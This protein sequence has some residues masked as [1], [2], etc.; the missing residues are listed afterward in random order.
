MT[1]EAMALEAGKRFYHG[2]RQYIYCDSLM[3]LEA[4]L[5]NLERSRVDFERKALVVGAALRQLQQD[6]AQADAPVTAQ[7]EELG[8]ELRKRRRLSGAVAP[9]A[10]QRP[11]WHV[12]IYEEKR[13][14]N[15]AAE[16]VAEK[17]QGVSQAMARVH[18]TVQQA[19]ASVDVAK[20]EAAPLLGAE[21]LS[22]AREARNGS[23]SGLL[24]MLGRSDL[25]RPNHVVVL[26]ELSVAAVW[27]L[28]GVSRAFRGWCSLALVAMPRV[29]A[30]GGMECIGD[31]VRWLGD[32]TTTVSLDL[33]TLA[34]GGASDVLPTKR[35]PCESF[36]LG[37]LPGGRL[38]VAGGLV[39]DETTA[40][41]F[42][43]ADGSGTTA[44]AFE[45][46]RGGVAWTSLPAMG[47]ARAEAAPAV[48]LYDGRLLVAGGF[49]TAGSTDLASVEVLAA[50]GS[51]WATLAPMASA[52]YGAAT[53]RLLGGEVIIAGGAI[54]MNQP[55]ASAELWEPTTNVWGPLPSM[56]QS[57]YGAA[58][59]VLPS[60]RFAVLGGA[61]P[62]RLDGCLNGYGSRDAEA[63]DPVSRAWQELPLMPHAFYKGAAV[64]V[65]GGLL[66][67]GG[68]SHAYAMLF[69]EESMRWFT[70]PREMPSSR[71]E[72]ALVHAPA[73]DF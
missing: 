64:A 52:R 55:L 39:N 2:P 13:P 70:L 10:G 56:A 12:E 69:E 54:G 58:G 46:A 19:R 1:L 26:G 16:E 63:Y 48:S 22:V 62:T 65:A 53:G 28:M 3:A 31:G 37:Q 50:D 68:S 61:K 43:W 33:A 20:A 47:I 73:R 41:A 67:V 57:R 71:I 40:A 23:C 14:F 30:I 29:V 27:R 36:S 21:R 17:L 15:E 45:W 72:H 51:E 32:W 4:S 8:A 66:A 5:A 9:P 24:E 7:R 42:E 11:D 60:G 35:A 25:G 59:C 38:V 34:W 44:A 49:N 18:V 6:V